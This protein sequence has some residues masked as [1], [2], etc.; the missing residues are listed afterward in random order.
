MSNICRTAT[1][2]RERG[3][4]AGSNYTDIYKWLMCSLGFCV[5]VCVC[6][7]V[8][9]R[10]RAH[11]CSVM[12]DSSQPPGLQ[13]T[14]LLCPWN[15]PHKNRPEGCHVFLRCSSPSGP[16]PHLLRLLHWWQGYPLSLW[17]LGNPVQGFAVAQFFKTVKLNENPI[18]LF[19]FYS[20][21]DNFI[22]LKITSNPETL[23][24]QQQYISGC[25]SE[26]RYY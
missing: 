11:V 16:G 23:D 22:F 13:P 14:R 15:F 5:C 2:Q 18:I 7:C 24:T 3:K 25:E 17:H 9:A 1:H 21:N 12:S 4:T 10:V 20:L 8:C 19:S 26:Y 6:V